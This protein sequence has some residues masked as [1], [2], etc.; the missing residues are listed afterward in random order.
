MS[1]VTTPV[2]PAKASPLAAAK[3]A[4]PEQ[5]LV[6]TKA[7]K[8]SSLKPMGY[9][10]METMSIVAPADWSFEDVMN[11]A[12]WAG[13]AAP[14]AQNAI[15]TTI[16]RVGSLIYVDSAA[17]TFF[18]ILRINKI[19]R[20]HMTNPCGVEL[21]CVGPSVDIKTGKPCPINVSTGLPWVDP[22]PEEKAA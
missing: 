16:D 13:V 2:K 10:H 22:K 9:G 15:K 11:P 21:I 19:V 1:D 5:A 7:F 14:I 8:P 6:R 12:A 4:R 3:T 18:G 20:D 17:N